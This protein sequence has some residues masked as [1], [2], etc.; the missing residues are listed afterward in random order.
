MNVLEFSHH[1]APV[2]AASPR[3]AKK[4]HLDC[5][6]GGAECGSEEQIVLRP[7]CWLLGLELGILVVL[8]IRGRTLIINAGDQLTSRGI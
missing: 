4:E 6:R 1:T 7:L 5:V 3:V 2:G 8:C